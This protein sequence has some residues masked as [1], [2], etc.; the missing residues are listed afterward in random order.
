MEVSNIE[1]S[2]GRKGKENTFAF[3]PEQTD[4]PEDFSVSLT[5]PSKDY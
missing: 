1:F 3:Q 4:G 5:E 2:K